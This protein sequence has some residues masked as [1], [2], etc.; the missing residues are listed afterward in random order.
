MA[1]D[2]AAMLHTRVMEAVI[3]G[4]TDEDVMVAAGSS[5]HGTGAKEDAVGVHIA[6][7]E[8]ETGTVKQTTK[9][10]VAQDEHRRFVL[11]ILVH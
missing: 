3:D 11:N 2:A 6:R 9:V 5:C 1:R 10:I 8:D 7:V 4:G